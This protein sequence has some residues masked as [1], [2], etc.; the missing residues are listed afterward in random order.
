[1][2]Q[3]S[4]IGA[5]LLVAYIIFV[6]YKGELPCWFKLLGIATSAQCSAT[7]VQSQCAAATSTTASGASAILG[8]LG[9]RGGSG[10]LG[11][12]LGNIGVGGSIGGINIGIGGV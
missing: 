1:M 12:I 4:V 6:I 10:T 9:A 7:L 11:T 2:N 8:G 5:A 3:S